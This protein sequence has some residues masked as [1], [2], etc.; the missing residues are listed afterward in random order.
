MPAV[1][2]FAAASVALALL[3]ATASSASAQ[4]K[5]DIGA[6]DTEIKIGN[7]MPYS[8]PASAYGIIGRTE[9][10]YFKKINEEGGINGRK[11]NFISYDDG[12]SPPKTVE[13]ARK[14][15]ESDEV[16]FIFNSL[17]T[18]P[19]SAIHKYMNSKKV[20]QLFVATGATKWNDPQNYPWTMGWQPNYQSETQIY[21]KWLLKNKP[22]AKI[23]VLFQNDDYGK[24]YLKGLKDGLGAKAASMIVIEESYETTEPTIDNHIVKLKSTG[25]DVFMNITTPKFAAQAIKK[26][27]EIGWK[28]LHFL[29]NVSASVGSVMKP[30]GFENGQDIISADYLKDVS[31][32]EW[33]NDP[34][35]KEFLAFMNKY[36]PEGDKLDKG[37]IVGYGVAQTLVQVLKQCGDNLTRENIM[38]EAANL[39]NFR[40]E[41]LLPG[42]QIN[43][44]PT[45]FA[46]I[47]Q[48]RLEKFK[49]E[50]W[51]LFGDVISA[52]V[53][54]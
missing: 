44:S 30:A 19:N 51:E 29:N 45:D 8:G 1:T 5:Y 34:G 49:G 7:I 46:P 26:N 14:L 2:K 38:K 36:F 39:K 37:T 53:G 48:L 17:G 12:Y 20:P 35:M 13:Q 31:D 54:G 23:A 47:S 40:T 41:A 15:V 28:P 11:I 16:L 27:A 25:A 33:N 24:D 18:P 3:A 42:I 22:D 9:A 6:T 21:A 52:D 4:K 50:R 32:P 43:T 10:A